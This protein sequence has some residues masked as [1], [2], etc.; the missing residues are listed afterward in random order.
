MVHI[1]VVVALKPTSGTT[2][3]SQ[4]PSV[5]PDALSL[6]TKLMVECARAGCVAPRFL[7]SADT[8]HGPVAPQR[9]TSTETT[10][11]RGGSDDKFEKSITLGGTAIPKS[12][13]KFE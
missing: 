12:R 8:T 2:G 10:V 6:I 1:T 7:I 4:L 9:E 5:L 11:Y 13:S 3:T